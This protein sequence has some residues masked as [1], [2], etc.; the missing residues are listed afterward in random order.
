MCCGLAID[1]WEHSFFLKIMRKTNLTD[2][3]VAKKRKFDEQFMLRMRQAQPSSPPGKVG[4]F[5]GNWGRKLSVQFQVRNSYKSNLEADF[6][7]A[8]GGVLLEAR[9][10]GRQSVIMT[11][12]ALGKGKGSEAIGTLLLEEPLRT[13]GIH[14]SELARFPIRDA[15][16]SDS[17]P[18]AGCTIR[19]ITASTCPPRVLRQ[20]DRRRMA[21]KT[22]LRNHCRTEDRQLDQESAQRMADRSGSNVTLLKGGGHLIFVSQPRAVARVPAK[23]PFTQNFLRP[24]D[25]RRNGRIWT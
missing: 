14:W 10:R 7:I 16:S 18:G 9:G 25:G 6:L 12:F 2:K 24:P 23:K 1:D 19:P 15:Q 20:I 21:R 22:E 8:E 11:E 5:K 13:D 4:S 17:I 3:Q